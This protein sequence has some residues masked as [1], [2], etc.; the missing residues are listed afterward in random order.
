MRTEK[1]I[2]LDVLM[3]KEL[4][5]PLS[6]NKRTAENKETIG[7]RFTYGQNQHYMQPSSEILHSGALYYKNL[8]QHHKIFLRRDI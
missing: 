1:N 2:S 4:F 5:L 6:R 7:G 8:T 3:N